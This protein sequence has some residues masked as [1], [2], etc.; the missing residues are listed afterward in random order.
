MKIKI[1]LQEKT[2]FFLGNINIAKADGQV[3]IDLSGKQDNVIGT[4]ASSIAM[5]II[6]SDTAYSS[7]VDQIKDVDLKKDL[8]IQ[9]GIE[10][11]DFQDTEEV[12]V[13]IVEAEV[14]VQVEDKEAEEV[15]TEI[16]VI[17]A[18]ILDGA[19]K[20]VATR[21]KKM[22]LTED[23]AKVLLAMEISGKKRIL[24]KKILGA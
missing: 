1:H 6:G 18:D 9:L 7:I 22:D 13:E 8:Q 15:A 19:S 16:R 21:I 11:T 14:E 3:E 24:I 4:I 10:S 23:E 20:T 5:G 12:K 2:F 17:T